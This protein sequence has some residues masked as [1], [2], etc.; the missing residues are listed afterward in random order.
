M[1]YY[2][3]ELRNLRIIMAVVIAGSMLS[4]AVNTYGFLWIL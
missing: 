2:S 4:I 3:T 1:N